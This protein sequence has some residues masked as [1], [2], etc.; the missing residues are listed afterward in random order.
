MQRVLREDSYSRTPTDELSLFLPSNHNR[1]ELHTHLMRQSLKFNAKKL[2][3]YWKI[4]NGIMAI[5]LA[6]GNT[7]VVSVTTGKPTG[8]LTDKHTGKHIDKATGKYNDQSRFPRQKM[9]SRIHRPA[10]R[11]HLTFENIFSKF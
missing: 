10:I 5:S 8:K 3:S 1:F 7:T 9:I 11:E 6:S 4:S 2:F